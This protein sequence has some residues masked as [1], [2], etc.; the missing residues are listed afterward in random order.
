MTPVEHQNPPAHDPVPHERTQRAGERTP[1]VVVNPVRAAVA[2]DAVKRHG[3]EEP[4]GV[5]GRLDDFTREAS[6]AQAEGGGEARDAGADDRDLH[7]DVNCRGR[8]SSRR[9]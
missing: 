1:R 7:A 3:R 6:L 2:R 4:T 5:R 8:W 9:G